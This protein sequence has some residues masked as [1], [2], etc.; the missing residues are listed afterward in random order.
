MQTTSNTRQVPLIPFRWCS[1]T[2]CLSTAKNFCRIYW[3]QALR[4]TIIWFLGFNSFNVSAQWAVNGTNIFNSNTG[5]VGIGTNTP[6]SKLHINTTASGTAVRITGPDV[7]LFMNAASI[8]TT[9]N[10]KD[11]NINAY[12]PPSF[13]A[14]APVPGNLVLQAFA[15]NIL[16]ETGNVGIGI[17]TPSAKLHLSSKLPGEIAKFN[18]GANSMYMGL[19]ENSTY[20]GYIGSYSGNNDDIDFGTGIGTNGKLH[21]AIKTLPKLT[22]DNTGKVGIGTT[23]PSHLLDVAGRMRIRSGGGSAGTWLA[24]AANTGDVG[25]MGL[26][27]DNYIGLY[28]NGGWGLLMNGNSGNVGI[29]TNSP[30][31]KLHVAGA[32][33]LANNTSISPSSI[34]HSVVAGIIQD[35]GGSI[36]SGIGGRGGAPGTAWAVGSSGTALKFNYSNGT[37]DNTMQT[38]MEIHANRNVLLV[39]ATGNVGVG[40]ATPAYKLDVCGTVRAKEIRVATGW[41]DYVFA[42]DYKLPSLSEVEA[43]IRKNKHLPDVT[44]G[45][46]IESEGLEVGKVSSQMIKKIEELTL[47]VIELQKQV[48]SLK[49]KQAKG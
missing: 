35:A 28:G 38:A 23:T 13:P 42:N 31:Q 6:A 8:A 33:I 41:C 27:N 34:P 14:P 30:L 40:V 29:G 44:P 9:N 37:I 43:F 47:Y 21:L 5:N 11:F 39:P 25:F 32:S 24:N 49:D 4:L 26:F 15:P 1:N 10:G 22:I 16:A 2:T 3:A 18:G 48:N 12:S 46:Q 17:T 7:S 19:Y 36:E 20:R 45:P